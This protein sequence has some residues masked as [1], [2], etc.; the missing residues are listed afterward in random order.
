MASGETYESEIPPRG[1]VVTPP[2]QDSDADS[3]EGQEQTTEDK[4]EEGAS[5]TD[6]VSESK[7]VLASG[8]SA[9]KSDVSGAQ[10][11]V[12]EKSDASYRLIII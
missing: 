4:L 6:T 9:G 7:V 5:A 1:D 8:E 11:P 3:G 10:H 12:E 2:V